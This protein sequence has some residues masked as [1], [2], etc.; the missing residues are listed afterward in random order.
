MF[1]YNADYTV[2]LS[3]LAVKC[4]LSTLGIVQD[5]N[6]LHRPHQSV[7]SLGIM[8]KNNSNQSVQY[9]RDVRG[10]SVRAV[11]GSP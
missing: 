7:T 10:V 6:F 4:E 5:W 3:V 1:I 9:H 2:N 8:R 11:I